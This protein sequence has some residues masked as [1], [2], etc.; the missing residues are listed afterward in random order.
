M[1]TQ[2]VNN[3]EDN[4]TFELLKGVVPW[5]VNYQN[6]TEAVKYL[7]DEI[8]NLNVVINQLEEEIQNLEDTLEMYREEDMYV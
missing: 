8:D 1:D 5:K 4:S 6:L 2:I 7:I 3:G